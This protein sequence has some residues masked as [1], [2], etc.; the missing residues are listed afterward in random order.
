MSVTSRVKKLFRRKS[1]S[2]PQKTFTDLVEALELLKR[3]AKNIAEQIF[4]ASLVSQPRPREAIEHAAW[5]LFLAM[6]EKN[7]NTMIANGRNPDIAGS[8]TRSAADT[9]QVI[10][11]QR[12]DE[13]IAHGNHGSGARN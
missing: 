1:Q 9:M 4:E 8:A 6:G 3:D 12:Y 7:Y 5:V 10:F 11:M 2:L 13:L